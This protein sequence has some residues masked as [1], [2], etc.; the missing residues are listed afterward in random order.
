[1]R[2]EFTVSAIS[3]PESLLGS[4]SSSLSAGRSIDLA[5][6]KKVLQVRRRRSYRVY[7]PSGY[8]G[9]QKLP[10]LVVLHGCKQTHLDMQATTGFDAIADRENFIVVYPYITSHAPLRSRNCWGWWL[11]RQR[12][13]DRGEVGDIQHIVDSVVSSFAVDSKRLHICGLSAGAAMSVVALATYSDIW[14]SGASVAGV[15]YGESARAVKF[16]RSIPVRYKAL[17]TLHRLL[18]AVL[19][20]DAPDLLVIQSTGD[21]LVDVA[22]SQNLVETWKHACALPTQSEK[23]AIGLSNEV[24]WRLAQYTNE[25]GH[26][27]LGYLTVDGIEHGWIGGQPGPYSLTEGPNIS[28]L[29]WAFF[30]K[31]K[32]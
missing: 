10:L 30:N 27:R 1:M 8:D 4:P 9:K 2:V 20:S 28:E 5:L 6:P 18:G 31:D 12:M 23:P 25:N 16:A 7:L 32:D 19:V 15:P 11:P 21:K 26:V 13:R 29:I 24:P 17:S 22:L 3:N 14:R